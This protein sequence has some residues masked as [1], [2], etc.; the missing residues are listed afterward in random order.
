VIITVITVD[1]VVNWIV[2]VMKGSMGFMTENMC[3]ITGHLKKS[4]ITSQTDAIIEGWW[5]NKKIEELRQLGYSDDYINK[6]LGHLVN[7]RI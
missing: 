4:N 1:M 3:E 5:I 2:R 7:W 6:K